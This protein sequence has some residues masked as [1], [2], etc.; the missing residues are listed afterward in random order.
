MNP[1]A[2]RIADSVVAGLPQLKAV[3]AT[4]DPVG[5]DESVRQWV[6]SRVVNGLNASVQ[7]TLPSVL[8]RI[9]ALT[10][11]QYN[12]LLE[13]WWADVQANYSAIVDSGVVDMDADSLAVVER[14][15]EF[16]RTW[17]PWTADGNLAD[18]RLNSMVLHPN[19]YPTLRRQAGCPVDKSSMWG[20]VA[21]TAAVVGGVSYLL[22]FRD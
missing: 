17:R 14:M 7:E 9:C 12:V 13:Q 18:P 3:Q 22:W 19:L 1:T 2:Q 20:I 21:L 11:A 8:V 10:P 16:M 5:W 15:R 6:L 4:A